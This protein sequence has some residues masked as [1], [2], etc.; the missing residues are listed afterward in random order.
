MEYP[1]GPA[2]SFIYNHV[3][4]P[5]FVKI[6]VC[7]KHCVVEMQHFRYRYKR[8]SVFSLWKYVTLICVG[9]LFYL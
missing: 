8:T 3:M 9:V 7:H 4:L 1:E 6:C 2:N 5:K